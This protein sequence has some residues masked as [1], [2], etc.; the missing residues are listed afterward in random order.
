M[1]H[2]RRF[3]HSVCPHDCPSTC[4]LEVEVLEGRRIGSVRGA[5]DNS[6]TA[7]VIC[8]K[9]Q[10]YAER[11]HHPDRLTQ[12][13]ART[14]PRGSGQYAP[15]GWDEALD[16]VAGAFTEATQKHGS[17]AV[18]PYYFAGTM[19]LVQ[20]DGIHR[21]RHA[22]RYS[23]QTNTICTS[24]S[25]SGWTAGV[26]R[27]TG[28]DPREMAVSDLIVVWGGNPVATQ[29]N[30]MTHVSRARKSRGAKF[31]VI[32]PYRT[33]TA[34]VADLH[35]APRPGT[36][37][38]LA[39]A[40]M[41]VAFRDGQADRAYMAKYADDPAALEAHLKTRDPAWAAAITGLSI[42]EIEAFAALYNGTPRAYIRAGYGFA[43]SR[44]GAAALH[45]VTCMPT[46]TGHWRHEG[47]GAF[48]N[49][50]SIYKWDKTL[51][52]GLDLRDTSTRSMDMSRIGAVLTGDRAELGDGPQVHAMLIQNVNP[53]TVAPDSNRV[54]AG[55]ARENLFVCV[56]EQFMTETARQADIVLPATMFLEHD[57]L[58]QAGG[59]S[60]IQIGAKL[61]E[62]PPGC[63]SN[64]EVIQGL[65]RRLGARHRGFEMTAME[66][67]DATLRESGWPGAET[68]LAQH[69][70]DVQPERE[71]SHFLDGFGHPDGRFRF[72][73]DWAA[74][75]PRHETM[76]K[77]PDHMATIDVATAEHPFR[78][79]TAPARQ[80]LNTSFTETPTGQQREGRPSVLL[81]AEDAARLGLAEGDRVQLGNLRG[82]IIVHA[83]IATG[84]QQPGVVVVEGIWP[85]EAF[86]TGIGVN[87]LTSD[88]PAPP[89]GGAVFHDT[90]VWIRAAS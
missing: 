53:M 12:P 67:V 2:Q 33:G 4:A 15:I 42:A 80:F 32:D 35:L 41:H 6:Y 65:A 69:W 38:A 83:R 39:C 37:G 84:G 50:R 27:I 55:F 21:L 88:D 81:N 14:G 45:A 59:H 74:L 29:V 62:P 20:R 49:N 52:E 70:L 72:A 48:W 71:T 46:V 63:R 8:S 34:A 60:H 10:R 51:I 3:E 79:V 90:A 61:V 9:V 22:M 28:P 31:V 24:I 5:K 86:E 57:D 7:G 13:L 68:V 87:A 25:E 47:G 66:M 89:A 11:I 78:M 36:D 56:H 85:S 16:R 1:T 76:P 43:R 26:G 54:R 19:G 40:V 75:G 23:R 64:H 82:Q 73:P 18:W 77:L 30:V 17:E 58:Y 44:N